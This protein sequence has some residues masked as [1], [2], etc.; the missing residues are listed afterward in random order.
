[1]FPLLR[2]AWRQSFLLSS[3]CSS[4]CPVLVLSRGKHITE[5]TRMKRR[6]ATCQQI[7]MAEDRKR[8]RIKNHL[9]FKEKRKRENALY[10][11]IEERVKLLKARI[12]VEDADPVPPND[13]ISN[14]E[15]EEEATSKKSRWPW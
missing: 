11:Q 6:I 7:L 8:G 13:G 12:L 4:L 2:P 14:A 3:S 10:A 5:R 1:M 15:L 9:K